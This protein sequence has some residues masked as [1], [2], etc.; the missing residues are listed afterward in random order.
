MPFFAKA[1]PRNA[2]PTLV[3]GGDGTM[4]LKIFGISLGVSLILEDK[5][6]QKNYETPCHWSSGWTTV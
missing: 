2:Y 5:Y 1:L 6:V 3:I 4:A